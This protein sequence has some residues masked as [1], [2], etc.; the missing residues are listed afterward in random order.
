MN[1]KHEVAGK[2]LVKA[3]EL[4]QRYGYTGLLH[5]TCTGSLWVL[6]FARKN[7]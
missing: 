4:A 2:T 1:A 7:G 6:T 3:M 5:Q